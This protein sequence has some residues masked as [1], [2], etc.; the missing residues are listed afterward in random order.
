MALPLGAL[1]DHF[2]R[3]KVLASSLFGSI[4][5]ILWILFVCKSFAPL[6][7]DIYAKTS[8][9]PPGRVGSGIPVH[10]IWASAGFYVFG[11]LSSANAMVYLM[12]ADAC[13]ESKR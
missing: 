10:W 13:P 11:N 1:A 3:K 6:P 4:A 9:V 12:A 5:G 2:G 8:L 7:S